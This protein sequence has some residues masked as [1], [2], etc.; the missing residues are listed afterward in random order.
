M[1]KE[2]ARKEFTRKRT[3]LTD[4][5]YFQLNQ[6][7]YNHFFAHVDLSFIKILHIYLSVE[8]KREADTWTL[9]DRLRREYPHIRLAVP[10][11]IAGDHLK[12]FFFEGLHQL[13][14]NK[15]GIAEPQQGIPVE[16][17]RLD[18]VLVPL[19]ALD[20]HGHRVGYGKGFYDRFLATCSSSCRK[21]GMS[22]FE[23]IDHLDD[24]D[25]WDVPLDQC[26]T[27]SGI[28]TFRS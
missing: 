27:P 23:P 1:T 25:E 6:Q 11:M 5:G 20:A 7:L 8:N 9:L 15:W 3:A 22:L 10:K 13:K 19:L 28:L 24:V 26:I 12:H 21:I 2:Q 16:V 14:V 4:G 17:D 18:A